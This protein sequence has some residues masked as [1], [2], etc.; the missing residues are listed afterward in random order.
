MQ[1]TGLGLLCKKRASREKSY[2]I[3]RANGENT[4]NHISSTPLHAG[5]GSKLAKII[6]R[7]FPFQPALEK[8]K[9]IQV[10]NRKGQKKTFLFT[11]SSSLD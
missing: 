8:K 9:T 2:I 5:G 6:L 4:K 1:L 7:I 11:I 10:A 3:S